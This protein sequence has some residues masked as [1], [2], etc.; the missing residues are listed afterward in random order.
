MLWE[1]SKLFARL[2]ETGVTTRTNLVYVYLS[3]MDTIGQFIDFENFA[4]HILNFSS[5]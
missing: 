5:E 4:C 3:E 1:P 2:S